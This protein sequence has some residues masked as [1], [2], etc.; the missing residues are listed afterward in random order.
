[1]FIPFQQAIRAATLCSYVTNTALKSK[2]ELSNLWQMTYFSSKT[3]IVDDNICSAI[4]T[5][6]ILVFIILLSNINVYRTAHFLLIISL[7]LKAVRPEKL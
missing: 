7:N 5:L 4:H 2:Y 3:K 1:M 6:Y